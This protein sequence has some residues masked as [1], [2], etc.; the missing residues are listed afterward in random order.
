MLIQNKGKMRTIK[1]PFFILLT[2]TVGIFYSCDQREDK[3]KVACIGDSITEGYGIEKAN[4]HSYP[5]VL[6]TLLGDGYSVLNAGRSSTTLQK[7]G[8]HPYSYS[9]EFSNVFMFEPD[10][11]VVSLGTND[12]KPIN[13][14]NS[15]IFQRD[16]QFLL[17]TLKQI[18]SR[19]K[20]YVCTP[21]PVFNSSWG[22]NDSTLVHGIIPV[23][24]RLTSEHHINLIDLNHIF[25][26]KNELTSDGIHPNELGARAIAEQ[27]FNEIHPH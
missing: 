21:V 17:D 4:E 3:I 1:H 12:T 11:I 16:Y 24:K 26:D 8:N 6:Q 13:W 9:K 18:K 7:N 14:V 5:F 19:P 25:E 10:I 27:V 23:V 2:T 15:E 22:I 20:I